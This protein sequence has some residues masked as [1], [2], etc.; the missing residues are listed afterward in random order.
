MFSLEKQRFSEALLSQLDS[1]YNFARWLTKDA[2]EAKD[3]VH[4]VVARVYLNGN[5]S[6][7]RS[8]IKA[9]LFKI[10]RTTQINRF[11]RMRY[12][13]TS[14]GYPEND[15]VLTSSA[16]SSGPDS[17]DPELVQRDMNKAR[18]IISVDLRAIFILADIEGFT[19]REIA[20]IEGMPVGTVKSRLRKARHAVR[21][22]LRTYHEKKVK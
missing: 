17:L 15:T 13:V 2:D 21:H 22:F 14:L 19:S 10:I 5:F 3:L 1:I 11:R 12:E 4:E 18:E 6:I 7:P 16:E 9:Y 8:E 20:E